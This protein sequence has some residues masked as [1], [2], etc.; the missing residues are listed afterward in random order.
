MTRN[1]SSLLLALL[2]TAACGS[3]RVYVLEMMPGPAY[4]G[5]G[6]IPP[7]MRKR[8]KEIPPRVEVLYATDREPA[9]EKDDVEYYRNERGGILRLGVARVQLGTESMDWDTVVARS[10][11]PD[12]KQPVK[13]K[14]ESIEE[15]GALDRTITAFTPPE[16]IPADPGAAAR[17]FAQE[18]N[19]RLQSSDHP[20][21]FVFVHGYKVRY[22]NPVLVATE[23]WHFLGYEGVFLAY[24]W[25]STPSLWA[26]F[27][28]LETGELSARNLRK[29]LVYLAAETQARR[30]HVL[31]YSAGT[32]LVALTLHQL[33]L[34]NA[35]RGR[36]WIQE[37]LRL[38]QV[39]LT[40]SDIDRHIFGAYL[41]DGIA[42]VPEHLTVYTSSTDSA[43]GPS[44]WVFGRRR[45]GR[46]FVEGEMS[47]TGA[48]YIRNSSDVSIVNVTGAEQADAGNGHAYFQKSPWVSSDLLATFAHGLSPGER[49]LVRE[50]DSPIWEFPPDYVEKL[51][52]AVRSA[53][54]GRAA[55]RESP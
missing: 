52:K 7:V 15:F 36:E 55:G 13:M 47:A 45:M 54:P 5:G 28:D 34:R 2:L 22:E 12:R 29:L 43:M 26:Y 11:E 32:R 40:G 19:E 53:S 4:Y 51:R 50:G 27:A 44:E 18:V 48:E 21:L 17:R 39:V 37:R 30:I 38:G 20:D 24:S 3:P 9:T 35:E 42:S 31:G 23:L 14:V 8:P 10:L 49:G 1:Q 25:P 46:M 41:L 33:A 16:Q 6:E